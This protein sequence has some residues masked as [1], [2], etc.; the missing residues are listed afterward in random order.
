MTLKGEVLNVYAALTA[1][2]VLLVSCTSWWSSRICYF[3]SS[4]VPNKKSGSSLK[5]PLES[6]KAGSVKK[7]KT[8]NQDDGKY[9]H[10]KP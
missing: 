5:K 8:V 9:E 6:K 4:Q 10:V 1:P 2:S 7:E 3:V